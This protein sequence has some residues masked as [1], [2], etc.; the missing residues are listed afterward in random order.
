L[1]SDDFV[2]MGFGAKQAV[3]L[4]NQL[5]RSRGEMIEDW[6]FLA[7]FGVFRIGLGPCEKL[8]AH[9]RLEEVFSLTEAD[10]IA[11]EG[12]AEKTAAIV[13]KGFKQIQPLFQTI[14]ALGFNLKMT[15]HAANA[16]A[17]AAHPLAGKTIVF[18][19]TM[20][21]GS[22]DDMKRQAKELGAKVSES[23][24]SKTDL[25]VI[26]EKVGAAKLQAAQEKGVKI[27][28]EQEYLKLLRE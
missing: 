9:Y 23:V 12:F 19:G 20:L 13:I 3:N 28:S 24:S 21:Q 26:G 16:I 17:S 2:A 14:Y 5:A 27:V 11:I 6:R 7:A 10:I 8:L 25:L 4:V 22:R 15:A 1:H 18:T